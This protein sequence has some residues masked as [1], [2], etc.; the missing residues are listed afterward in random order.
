MNRLSQRLAAG[1]SGRRL[2]LVGYLPA[3][4]PGREEFVACVRA[5]FEAGADAMEIA[6]SNPPLPMDGPRIQQAAQLGARNVS[7]P[8]DALQR[9]AGARV[10]PD[11]SVVALAYRAA[12]DELGAERFLE[13]CVDGG[14][15]AL[16][17]PQHTMAEQ[18]EMAHRSRAVGLEQ[19]VFLHLQEDLPALAASGLTRPVVYLQ[20]ADLQTGGRFDAAKA[21]ERL[22]EVREALAGRDAHV[23]VG[24]G[25]RGPEEAAALLDSTA[26]GVIVGT[27]LVEAAA[28]GPGAVR[29]LVGRMQPALTRNL[30]AR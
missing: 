7:G 28:D 26:D 25:V 5:A 17:M 9:A 1:R 14:A 3:G 2:V 13:V 15:D 10:Q 6:L 20:S 19:L 21:V 12:F 23:L 16:L 29:E 11:Q 22:G 24:F 30:A 4:Y 8:L 18:L 27:S